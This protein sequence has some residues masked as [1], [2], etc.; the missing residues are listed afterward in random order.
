MRNHYA[1][2]VCSVH[3][4]NETVSVQ[5]PCRNYCE[6]FQKKKGRSPHGSRMILPDKPSRAESAKSLA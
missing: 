1:L 4:L 6:K 2:P 5:T 3:S